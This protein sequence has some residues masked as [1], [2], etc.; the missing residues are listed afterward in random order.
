MRWLALALLS[1]VLAGCATTSSPSASPPFS[2]QGEC[3]RT[4]G[5]WHA[6]ANLPFCE[7]QSPGGLPLR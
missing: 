3:E 1:L 4:G 6:D 7:Y 2:P 5:W